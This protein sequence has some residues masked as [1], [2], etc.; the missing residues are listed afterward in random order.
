MTMRDKPPLDFVNL[1]ARIMAS[2]AKPLP[3]ASIVQSWWM[4]LAP[5]EDNVVRKSFA[6]Y[7]VERPDHA[8][9]P[10]SIAARCKLLD[11][12]P[13]ENEA[14]AL[15]LNSRDEAE[16]VVWTVE[17]A[18][19]FALCSPVLVAGDEVG[20]RMAFKDAYSRLVAEAR[21]ANVPV[22]W[23]ASQGWD[24]GRRV[25]TLKR[26]ANAGLLARPLITALL[27]ISEGVAN[28]DEK[29]RAQLAKIKKMLAD[30]RTAKDAAYAAAAERERL[31]NEAWQRA[32]SE[33]VSRY[34]KDNS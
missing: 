28:N 7:S 32:T 9:V 17:C 10:N 31:A 25:A 19:A 13:D 1:L 30:S 26:A 27:P 14:W 6:A 11:G 33:R 20:A 18:R 8:P 5:F 16:T 23:S 4:M 24:Q 29:A 12:R 15:A 22:E 34:L 3:D 2:Y 21:A